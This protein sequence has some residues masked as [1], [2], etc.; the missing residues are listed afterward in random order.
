MD[1][2]LVDAYFRSYT[3]LNSKQGDIATAFV[4]A[5]VECRGRQEHLCGD[6]SWLYETRNSS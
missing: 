2:N 6:A 4:H 5:A 1:N 3:H